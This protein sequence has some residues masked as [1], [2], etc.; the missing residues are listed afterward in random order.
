M[1]SG[2]NP[3]ENSKFSELCIVVK[4]MFS[5]KKMEINLTTEKLCF[6]LRFFNGKNLSDHF[7]N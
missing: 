5:E 6:I 7:K 2:D 1:N 3:I 4:K